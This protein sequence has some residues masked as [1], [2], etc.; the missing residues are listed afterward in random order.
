M[1]YHKAREKNLSFSLYIQ[2]NI[3]DTLTG[4]A[5]RLTQIL[6]N[7]ISNAIKFTQKGGISINITSQ[8]PTDDAVRLRFSVKDSGI[9]ILTDKLD[10]IFERFQQGET[11]TTRKY[12]G[13]GLGLSIVRN[14]VQ[15]QGGQISV[16]SDPG[17]GTE[18]VF[19]IEYSLVPVGEAM[20]TSFSDKTEIN[21]G[22]FPDARVLVVEDNA[23]NQ[24]LIKFTFQSWKVN[25]ELADN[26]SKAIEWLQRETFH[27]VL[28]DIQMPLM[29]GYATV[30]AIR[31]ELKS[32]IPV[33][34]MTAHA[35]A[36]E[37]EKCLSYG[38]NDYISKPIHE[39]ELFNLL[40]RYLADDR[41]SNIETLKN[42]LHY[43]DLNFLEDMVM[44]SG[45]FLNTIIKQFLKQFPGEMDALKKAI[46]KKDAR[47]VASL[48][49]H[50]QST[51]SILG[52]N[53]PFFQQLE[54]LEKL[55]KKNTSSSVLSTE[56][57]KLHDY[58][59]HLLQEVNQLLNARVF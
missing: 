21:A 2:D 46:D 26:G 34:A 38:M 27:L 44:G 16:D 15:L 35:L 50:I 33:I 4:D 6:V 10:D 3:P 53:T 57:D 58:K 56:F 43:I 9:G 36:G 47:E 55:A 31:K 13:T 59:H 40:K 7:L 19:D 1:F 37:R 29:D 54:K 30:Q 18:F 25:F 45:D 49:H 39:K 32:D 41:N 28:L 22:A 51:V 23:M 20:S 11:D 17:K 48:S 8:P 14:L 24:L 52:K 42:D 5:V 12:G